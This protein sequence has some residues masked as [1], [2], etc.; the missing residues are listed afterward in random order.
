MKV[1]S[2]GWITYYLDDQDVQKSIHQSVLDPVAPSKSSYE[3][4]PVI[5]PEPTRKVSEEK[6]RH[7]PHKSSIFEDELRDRMSPFHMDDDGVFLTRPG[8]FL[9]GGRGYGNR[10]VLSP[11]PPENCIVD[12][13]GSRYT[14]RTSCSLHGMG[15]DIGIQYP[16][17]VST[18]KGP[19]GMPMPYR[20]SELVSEPPLIHDYEMIGSYTRTPPPFPP[21]YDYPPPLPGYRLP[22][23]STT[24][25]D[26]F[27]GSSSL[28]PLGQHSSHRHQH[29]G[30]PF[31]ML[32]FTFSSLFLL[33]MCYRYLR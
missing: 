27:S 33:L 5:M 26:R 30:I 14:H 28:M 4:D 20:T 8:D 7:T 13:F 1:C 29:S 17:T 23:P 18:T 16:E 3:E 10:R 22:P 19:L 9:D 24:Y 11:L 2:F 32:F 31:G 21:G 6:I 12:D 25:P 15:S